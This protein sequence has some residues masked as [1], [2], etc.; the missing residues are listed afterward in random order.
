VHGI[1]DVGTHAIH[2]WSVL[3]G[4][5]V[6][7]TSTP[8][9][10]PTLGKAY[11]GRSDGIV[12]QIDLSSGASEALYPYGPGNFLFDPSVDPAMGTPGSG[13]L[14][15]A[16]GFSAGSVSQFCVPASY[17]TCLSDAACTAWGGACVTGV[18]DPIE[19][20]CFARPKSD[21][22]A[23]S[24]GMACTTGDACHA[25]LC[26]P[27][28]ASA[29]ACVNAGDSACGSGLSCCGG[30]VCANLQTDNAHCG[31]CANACAADRVCTNGACLAA[32]AAC[33]SPMPATLASAGPVLGGGDGLAFDRPTGAVGSLCSAYVSTYRYPVA[34]VVSR[35]DPTGAVQTM[36]SPSTDL[37]PLG[38]ITTPREG[39]LLFT[40][41]LNRPAGSFPTTLPALITGTFSPAQLAIA[42]TTSPTSSSVPFTTTIYDQGPVG[43]AFDYK[44]YTSTGGDS[45]LYFGNWGT[46]GDVVQMRR[47]CPF[48]EWT[49]TTVPVSILPAG[50]RITAITFEQH[51][52][53]GP[54]QGH[55][56]LYVGHGTILSIVDL[57]SGAQQNL[58][59]ASAAP[60]PATTAILGLAV[61]PVYGDIYVEIKDATGTRNL[62]DID[63]HDLS[64]RLAR[65]VQMDLH[66]QS[67]IPQGFS[68]DGRLTIA[69]DNSVWRLVPPT[70]V[71]AT[72]TF[73]AYQVAR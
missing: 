5:G 40:A 56:N 58:D 55:R 26:E 32:P 54:T 46:N 7:F 15:A 52:S 22:L 16:A 20:V 9:A 28:D 45:R 6:Q 70:V 36:T 47:T 34:S 51:K 66:L 27:G 50:D 48:C 10:L 4:P 44:T 13:R 63:E 1:T 62:L 53:P 65:D 37:A 41:A 43:P 71:G 2:D 35:V 3:P 8:V 59:L 19:H 69:P 18:C 14:T 49:R 72:P 61:H 17:G 39:N 24:D 42:S 57:D 60:P 33:L 23:C 29:C 25:G 38:G 12:Q 21:G 64:I 11:L 73:S 67:S 30:G 68:N 31:S